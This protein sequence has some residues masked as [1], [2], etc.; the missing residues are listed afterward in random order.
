MVR[1]YAREMHQGLH[2]R[3]LVAGTCL[4]LLL[5]LQLQQPRKG[6]PSPG[7]HRRSRAGLAWALVA[8]RAT[9]KGGKRGKRHR[10]VKNFIFFIFSL[11]IVLTYTFQPAHEMNVII[12]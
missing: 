11:S 3:K 6:A 1:A 2:A 10:K 9:H 5:L 7:G 8:A 4:F 12:L